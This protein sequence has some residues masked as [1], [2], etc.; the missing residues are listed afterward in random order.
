VLGLQKRI[1]ELERVLARKALE[2]EE[3][4]KPS[5]SRASNYP[6][7]RKAAGTDRGLFLGDQKWRAAFT[8]Y[9]RQ[10][11]TEVSPHP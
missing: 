7:G 11:Y 10:K 4:K 3:L 2:V 9:F 6:R 1:E 5:S 8:A